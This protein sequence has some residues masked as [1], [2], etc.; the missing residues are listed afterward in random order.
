ELGLSGSS[1]LYD[2]FVQLEAVTPG[3]FKNKGKQVQIQY[4]IHATPLG[5]MFVAVTSRGVCRAGFMD[6]SSST[7][8]LADLGHSWPFSSITES[9]ASTQYVINAIF[10]GNKLEK[11][12]PLSLHVAGTNFQVAVW[13]A[14]LKIPPGAITS[15]AQ[16][17]RWVGSPMAARAVGNA[18]GANPV[19][20][21]I[22]CHRVIQQSGA[23]GGYRWGP[24]RKA[25]VQKWERVRDQT[26][27]I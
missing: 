10:G 16:V 26:I 20:L 8:L 22:P 7:E 2:H 23:L 11:S 9:P 21:L 4:G 19:A 13:R 5:H 6:F 15:Y 14:L 27:E 3:E 25:M 24:A 18:I 17:A 12:G 1:R